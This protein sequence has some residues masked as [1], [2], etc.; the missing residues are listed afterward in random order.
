MAAIERARLDLPV[1]PARTRRQSI[2]TGRPLLRHA[3]HRIKGRLNRRPAVPLTASIIVNPNGQNGRK[4]TASSCALQEHCR[5]MVPMSG[6]VAS[7]AIE[8]AEKLASARLGS[9]EPYEMPHLS[10]CA[11][12]KVWWTREHGYGGTFSAANTLSQYMKYRCPPL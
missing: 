1:C 9:T 3:Q 2:F 11:S 4:S 8:G 12:I 6:V 7:R 10:Y 5:R